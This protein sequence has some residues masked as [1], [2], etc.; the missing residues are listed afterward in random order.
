[1]VVLDGTAFDTMLT[2]FTRFAFE[3]IIFI[4]LITPFRHHSFT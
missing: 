2:P 4:M 1:M 3:Q